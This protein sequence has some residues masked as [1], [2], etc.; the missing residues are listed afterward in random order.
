[1]LLNNFIVMIIIPLLDAELSTKLSKDFAVFHRRNR[2]RFDH[3]TIKQ[4]ELVNSVI[5]SVA[6]RLNEVTGR[7]F[8]IEDYIMK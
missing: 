1:M 5:H 3:F 8:G 7:T 2:Q 4:K 6:E